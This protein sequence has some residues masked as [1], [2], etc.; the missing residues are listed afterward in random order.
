MDVHKQ[1]ADGGEVLEDVS[2]TR[3]A[4]LPRVGD[5]ANELN[6]FFL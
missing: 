3:Y 2:V 1:W 6:T 5:E 4:Y